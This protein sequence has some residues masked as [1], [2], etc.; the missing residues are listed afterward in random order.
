MRELCNTP[1]KMEEFRR[2]YEIPDSI[3]LELADVGDVHQATWETIHMPVVDIVEGG[4]RF[5]L[6]PLLRETLAYYRLCPR[7]VSPNMIRII[8]GVVELNRLLGTSLGVWDI[9]FCYSACRAPSGTFYL[10]CRK[11]FMKLVT[12]LPDSARGEDL[13]FFKVTGPYE[14]D[15]SHAHCPHVPGYLR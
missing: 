12:D 11:D 5:P 6:H 10:K 1:A 2:R 15:R 13:D 3:G 4:V 14:D 7:Q 8:M 9:Q